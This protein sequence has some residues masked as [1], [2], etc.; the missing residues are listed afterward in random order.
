[1][2]LVESL[3]HGLVERSAL[4]LEAAVDIVD[5][6][7]EVRHEMAQAG[8]VETENDVSLTLLTTISLSL[9]QDLTNR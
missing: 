5:T 6:A 8:R 4:S 2:L 1:M 9:K 7:I 3:I